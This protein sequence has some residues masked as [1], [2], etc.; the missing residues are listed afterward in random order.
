MEFAQTL[1]EKHHVATVPGVAFGE[2]QA[3]RMSYATSMV[4]IEEG[5]ERL[6]SFMR[7]KL[8]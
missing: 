3:I 1:L 6:E 2:D 8:S 4:A 7:S 5:L